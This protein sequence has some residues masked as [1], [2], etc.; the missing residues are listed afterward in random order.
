VTKKYLKWAGEGINFLKNI[1]PW[2]SKKQE[3]L[4]HLPEYLD[5]LKR[6]KFSVTA[7]L[8]RE[9]ILRK[10]TTET[11]SPAI[12]D[13]FNLT[14][15]LPE[16]ELFTNFEREPDR[17]SQVKK[18]INALYH[19]ERSL[20]NVEN[21]SIDVSVQFGKD[22]WNLWKHTLG[23][24]YRA[25]QLITHLDIDLREIF[26]KELALLAPI[27]SI[28]K[29]FADRSVEKKQGLLSRIKYQKAAHHAGF[30]GGVLIDQL[31][32]AGG[33]VDYEFLT[34]VSVALPGYL[35]KLRGYVEQFSA[36]IS[37]NESTIDKKALDI[38]QDNALQL[39]HA[40]D[41]TREGHLF[42]PIKIV[43]YIRMIRHTIT[44]SMSIF[45]QAGYLTES[46]QDVVRAQLAR[47]KYDVLPFLFE[48]VDKMEEDAML[49]PGT[50][51]KSLMTVAKDLY[52]TIIKYV[53]KFVDFSKKG[54]ELVT[55]EDSQFV[56]KRLAYAHKRLVVEREALLKAEPVSEAVRLFFETLSAQQA[57]HQR[58]IDLPLNVRSTLKEQYKVFQPLVIKHDVVL[59][60]A[61][62]H[63]LTQKE[64]GWRDTFSWKY[65]DKISSILE[66]Q[67]NMEAQ[68]EKQSASHHFHIQLITDQILSISSDVPFLRLFPYDKGHDPFAINEFDIICLKVA[69]EREHLL[70]QPRP[71]TYEQ[72]LA[73][74]QLA[75]KTDAFSVAAKGSN[76]I[77]SMNDL[78]ASDVLSLYRVYQ[79]RC[80]QLTKALEAYHEF[81]RILTTQDN[82]RPWKQLD[83][84][85]RRRLRNLYSIFQPYVISGLSQGVGEEVAA[86]FDRDLI[87]V[88]SSQETLAQ[89]KKKI[90]G[91]STFDIRVRHELICRRF[92]AAYRYEK[93]RCGLFVEQIKT[94]TRLEEENRELS[95]EQQ[96]VRAHYVLKQN[97][98]S[99]AIAELSTSLER[100]IKDKDGKPT[101]VFSLPV[102][103]RLVKA[104]SG[105]PFPE[106][107]KKNQQL[108]QSSQVATLKR[109]FN[110][111]YHLEEI[112]KKLESLNDKSYEWKYSFS[113]ILIGHHLYQVQS[114]LR[115]IAEAPVWQVI[116]GEIWDGIQ[117]A[118]RALMEMRQYYIPEPIEEG[119]IT[120]DLVDGHFPV[121]F[122]SLTALKVLPEHIQAIRGQTNI[123]QEQTAAL[124]Q[125][126]EKVTA[127]IERIFTN[128]SSYFK[129]FFEIPAIY[130]LLRQLKANLADAAAASNQ[131]VM[132]NLAFIHYELL[133]KILLEG[134][135][136]EDVSCLMPGTLT[137]PLKK[138][139]DT[140]YQGLLE[141]LGLTS[142]R[143]IALVTSMFPIE[144]RIC[145]AEQR[146]AGAEGEK[147]TVDDKCKSI[148]RL[149]DCLKH[150]YNKIDLGPEESLP[151]ISKF[152]EE[153]Q[154]DLPMIKE[155]MPL[156]GADCPT[157]VDLVLD[158]CVLKPSVLN[159]IHV[160][161]ERCV[162]YYQGLSATQELI[163]HTAKEKIKYL[164]GVDGVIHCQLKA[165]RQFIEEYAK[166][167][168]DQQAT[169]LSERPV[170][171][172]HRQ[173]EYRQHLSDCLNETKDRVVLASK[174]EEDVNGTIGQLLADK[175]KQFEAEHFKQYYHLESI[176]AAINYLK[177]YL[178][179]SSTALS[180]SS[181]AIHKKSFMFESEQTLRKKS[182]LMRELEELA[183][184][185][186]LSMTQRIS[187]V[188]EYVKK[189]SFETQILDYHH[190]DA[191]TF[192]WLKQCLAWLL[193]WIGCYTPER[194]KCHKQ[195]MDAAKP[196]VGDVGVLGFFASRVRPYSPPSITPDGAPGI[197]SAT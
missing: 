116:K 19:V 80:E 114:L 108:A 157:N 89:Q 26:Y 14:D 37:Q 29:N 192:G 129:L 126:T 18:I 1:I 16:G 165:N 45:K 136:F 20:I 51:S 191:F 67:S 98:Y 189:R 63:G 4:S 111:L 70:Q 76:I 117:V 71:Q 155:I 88:L 176:I 112:A 172:V 194:R 10:L 60:K 186:K 166:K 25:C 61:I 115:R 87:A 84:S 156:L 170:G 184:D 197:P 110:C 179:Q 12:R 163:S 105:L 2:I 135:R 30:F 22:L 181:S 57:S 167:S 187:S 120:R 32:P 62:L 46:T 90:N 85:T 171:F 48:L 41:R 47:L 193:E 109:I 40:L 21:F 174:N 190:Y 42:L 122:Y 50:L 99:K 66:L 39:L 113:V 28:V 34:Q 183:L 56:R 91:I 153:Y 195:L 86:N 15:P 31:N 35:D 125:H 158:D 139:L 36:T 152:M 154:N 101:A 180:T 146:V 93:E 54:S 59:N 79:Q 78:S 134:D 196:P 188:Q 150:Y 33:G 185:E 107:G 96:A 3:F 104:S 94:V 169:E 151:F 65:E 77:T 43:H 124:H 161:L 173:K 119:G 162:S 74:D 149:L 121:L 53:H 5:Y 177:H 95:S 69:A 128:S 148:K 58:L 182:K 6:Q 8:V 130:Q 11:F 140:F 23:H 131:L 133:T 27:F 68:L 24:I 147:K 142:Q 106:L 164:S 75:Q 44:L 49:A 145:A 38:L 13:R 132:D 141:P 97:H 73:M 160:L 64:K 137:S 82:P 83:D 103:E 7:R 159:P 55:I 144:Q 92:D 168:F 102:R 100:L 52:K 143:H 72:H 81:Y 9:E 138:I 123:S 17:I 178:H 118:Y 127:D 175:V